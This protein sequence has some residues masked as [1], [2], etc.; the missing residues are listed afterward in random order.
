MFPGLPVL[1]QVNLAIAWLADA[2][3]ALAPPHQWAT[4]GSPFFFRPRR[5]QRPVSFSR[6][7]TQTGVKNESQEWYP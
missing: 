5:R 7:C 4:G 3:Y 2:V 1:E 6:Q